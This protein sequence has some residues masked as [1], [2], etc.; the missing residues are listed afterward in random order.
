LES[1]FK[2][3]LQ[4]T[5]KICNWKQKLKGQKLPE[6]FKRLSPSITPFGKRKIMNI[7]LRIAKATKLS[8]SKTEL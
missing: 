7:K 4:T 6:N 3:S 5:G 2:A 8:I 1:T